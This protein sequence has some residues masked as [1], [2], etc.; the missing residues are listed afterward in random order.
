MLKSDLQKPK[1]QEIIEEAEKILKA[2]KI[3]EQKFPF[4]AKNF[5]H[6]ITMVKEEMEKAA[7]LI[8]GGANE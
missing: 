3:V 4:I 7:K 5:K 2:H 6:Q 1:P 8:G